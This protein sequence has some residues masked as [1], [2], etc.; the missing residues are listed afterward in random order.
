ML[1]NAQPVPC[2]CGLAPRHCGWLHATAAGPTPLRLVPCHRRRLGGVAPHW[3]TAAPGVTRVT[4]AV[5]GR[6]LWPGW[7]I[8]AAVRRRWGGTSGT[9]GTRLPTSVAA[10]GR[11]ARHRQAPRHEFLTSLRTYMHDGEA[12]RQD[13]VAV[14][15]GQGYP[16]LPCTSPV[17]RAPGDRPPRTVAW[18]SGP[19]NAA[20]WF[21]VRRHVQSLPHLLLL[22]NCCRS[23]TK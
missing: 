2:R 9:D 11:G 23:M 15:D 7:P 10:T 1:V 19:G 6:S 20:R 17:I 18:P 4:G 13:A 3:H 16:I 12:R 5:H 14:S 21:R 22:S 8:V